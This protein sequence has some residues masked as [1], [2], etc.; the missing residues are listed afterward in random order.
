MKVGMIK[1]GYGISS[2]IRMFWTVH[3]VYILCSGILVL[4]ACLTGVFSALKQEPSQNIIDFALLRLCKNE[5][6]FL[7]FFL[8]RALMFGGLLFLICILRHRI[9]GFL[10][11]PILCVI[12]FCFG[13]DLTMISLIFGISGT[14][15]IIFAIFI[16]Q[17][18]YL[19]L[20]VIL[21]SLILRQAHDIARFGKYC[22][23]SFLKIFLIFLGVLFGIAI[24]QGIL[25][26]ILF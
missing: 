15:G 18:A 19:F 21:S 13:F 6:S 26:G 20:F 1:R 12:A 8:C 14:L 16:C 2:T 10:I 5:F 9:L 23:D 22:C 4:A 11:Y 3:K 25:I 7:G 24:I 17:I